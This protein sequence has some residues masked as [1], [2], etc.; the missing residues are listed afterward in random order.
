M[1]VGGVFMFW[2]TDSRQFVAAFI[3]FDDFT[4]Q[5]AIDVIRGRKT[6]Q[7]FNNAPGAFGEALLDLRVNKTV[8]QMD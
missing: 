4:E 7:Y 8:H 3:C 1:H 2:G 6:S 5:S